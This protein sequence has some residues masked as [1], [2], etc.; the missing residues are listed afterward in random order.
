MLRR[1]KDK[2]NAFADQV[3]SGFNPGRDEPGENK[4]SL[5]AEPHGTI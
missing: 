1:P 3:Q 4:L 2:R 5:G